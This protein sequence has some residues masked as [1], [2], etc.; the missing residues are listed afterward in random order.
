M[1]T[2]VN[3]VVEINPTWLDEWLSVV[4]A[5]LILAKNYEVYGC[6]FGVRNNASFEPLFANRGLPN[7]CSKQVLED[8]KLSAD[9]Y[10]DPSWCTYKELSEIDLEEMS[11]EPVEWIEVKDTKH[12][13]RSHPEQTV[14]KHISRGEALADPDFQTLFKL[15]GVLAERHGKERVRLVV[16]FDN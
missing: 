10:Y 13:L 12:F 5:G 6:L 9:E 7:D 8:Y 2:S 11:R 4:D 14:R 3:G 16:Y 15:M 1:G